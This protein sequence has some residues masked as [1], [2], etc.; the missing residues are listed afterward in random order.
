MGGQAETHVFGV[1]SDPN[2]FEELNTYSGCL[3]RRFRY[4]LAEFTQHRLGIGVA[5]KG[6]NCRGLLRRLPRRNLNC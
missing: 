5:S 1:L 3:T 6:M 4:S 2:R